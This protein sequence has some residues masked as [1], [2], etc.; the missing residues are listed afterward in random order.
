MKKTIVGLAI[1]SVMLFTGCSNDS[2]KKNETD[3]SKVE[4]LE[5]R[6]KELENTSSSE[7]TESD[8]A[9]EI[10]KA[11]KS[12]GLPVFNEKN[13]SSE[14]LNE[15][16]WVSSVSFQYKPEK[17][18]NEDE[19]VANT[20]S[21]VIANDS[22]GIKQ[23]VENNDTRNSNATEDYSS[24]KVKTATNEKIN[25]VLTVGS[26]ISDEDFNK[27]KEVFESIK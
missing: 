18:L 15:N 8:K 19:L 2:K 9:S 13:S 25:A 6:V 16:D 11:F 12:K 22:S 5:S 26:A 23:V 14:I 10:V 27:Y 21:F 1:L 7:K 17:E 3:D 4:Q 20:I 24:W